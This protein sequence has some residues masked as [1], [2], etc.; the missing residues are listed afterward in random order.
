MDSFNARGVL[1][2]G[3]GGWGK[4]WLATATCDEVF[5][6]VVGGRDLEANTLVTPLPLLPLSPLFIASC[7]DRSCP[8]MATIVS[9]L[10][11]QLWQP[12]CMAQYEREKGNYL[13]VLVPL[14]P[15]PSS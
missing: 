3:A 14:S 4:S 9:K 2:W 5:T 15:P 7:P 6:I 8:G 10:W 1:V 11:Q 13:F 12:L